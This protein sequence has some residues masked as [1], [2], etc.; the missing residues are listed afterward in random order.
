MDA[1]TT[2][3]KPMER[4]KKRKALDKERRLHTA[5]EETKPKSSM[6][7]ELKTTDPLA[8]T[9]SVS[10]SAAAAS[11]SGVLPEFHV[12]VFKDLA[13]ADGSVREA[14]AEALATE[15]MEVQRAY[16][17]LENKELVEGGG[18]KLE[19]EKD[20]GLNDCAPSL[21]YALRRLIRGVSS[22]RECARQGF[23]LGLT[24]LVST[25]HS[26]KVDSLLKLIVDFLEVSSSMKGQEQRDRLLGRLF[27]YGALGRSGRLAE[28]WISD[29]NTPPSRNSLVF[30]IAL[31]SKKRY[32]QEP[33]VSV[34]LA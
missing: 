9:A 4:Q 33:A 18:V 7:V 26:I 6:D 20:D 25:I 21:R 3:V 34:L 10:S 5:E 12:G 27:A 1:E 8:A 13:S 30:F 16:E 28:E 17:G 32:L 15:L 11:S 14:A 29:R 22:S 24:I 2:T 19:A 31:A 23:A